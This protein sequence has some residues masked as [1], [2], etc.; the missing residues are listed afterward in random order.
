MTWAGALRASRPLS[1]NMLLYWAFMEQMISRSVRVFNFGRCN[2]GGGTHH[3][4]QQWGGADVPLPW[5]HY[6]PN[7]VKATPSPD[8][9]AFSWGPRL[10]RRLPLSI[11]NLLGPRL[12]RF[13]P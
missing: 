1:A 11:A 10:W 13:L 2:P 8:D 12:V 3:F 9:S 7:G 5:R 4:K 6:A